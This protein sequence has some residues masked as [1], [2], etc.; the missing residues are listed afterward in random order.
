MYTVTGQYQ[1]LLKSFDINS[2]YSVVF[3][4]IILISLS[5]LYGKIFSFEL[6]YLSNFVILWSLIS[7]QSILLRLILKE[8]ILSISYNPLITHV[9]IYGAGIFGSQLANTLKF[10]SYKVINFIDD[11]SKLGQKLNGYL[12]YLQNQLNILT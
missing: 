8:V 2:I 1:S 6:P 10:P 12:Y 9:A 4:N 5:A 11:D 7:I 3:R